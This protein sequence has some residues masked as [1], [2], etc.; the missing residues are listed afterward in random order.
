MFSECSDHFT[1]NA[2][3]EGGAPRGDGL[4][5]AVGAIAD[6]DKPEITG[7]RV[8]VYLT[9]HEPYRVTWRDGPF[10]LHEQRRC[11]AQLKLELPRDVRK[12]AKAGAAIAASIEPF[13][14]TAQAKRAPAYNA[15][16]VESLPK[17]YERTR[18]AWEVWHATQVNTAIDQRFDTSLR[19]AQ[20]R[21]R[22]A[23]YQRF[24][25][26]GARSRSDQSFGSC[27]SLLTAYFSSCG[28]YENQRG[29]DDG[30]RSAWTLGI[31]RALGACRVATPATP[32]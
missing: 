18:T 17:D 31:V 1:D 30:Q 20:G 2:V 3:P 8:D 29:F 14:D 21:G 12:D 6:V 32:R 22:D 15:R 13:P 5:F 4:C 7:T 27:E 10:T 25:G 16:Q 19:E 9:L 26:K 23:D 28:S 24:F 11:R